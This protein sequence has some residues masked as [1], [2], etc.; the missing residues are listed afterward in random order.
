M[1]HEGKQTWFFFV[2]FFFS[3]SWDWWGLHTVP[4]S[5]PALI[6]AL[7]PKN[8]I[9]CIL[10]QCRTWAIPLLHH[11]LLIKG[12]NNKQMSTTPGTQ[13]IRV[14]SWIWKNVVVEMSKLIKTFSKSSFLFSFQWSCGRQKTKSYPTGCVWQMHPGEHDLQANLHSDF[15]HSKFNYRMLQMCH[16]CGCWLHMCEA[17]AAALTSLWVK[18]FFFYSKCAVTIIYHVNDIS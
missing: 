15:C 17:A 5:T 4:P 6:I 14:K 7:T 18:D 9:I 8:V 11:G 13:S 3:S 1:S 10:N 2:S 12:K 16:G